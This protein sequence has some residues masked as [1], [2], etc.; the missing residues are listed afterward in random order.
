MGLKRAR[1]NNESQG[2]CKLAIDED[3][4]IYTIDLLKQGLSEEIAV[5]DRFELNLSAVEEIDSSGIQLLL[6]LRT[7]LMKKKKELKIS[8]ASGAVLSLMESYGISSHFDMED[9]S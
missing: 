2:L 7:E 1:G 5:Y 9:G 3:L 6:A 4:S 8:A